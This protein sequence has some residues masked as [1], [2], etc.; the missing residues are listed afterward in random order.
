M[1]PKHAH[2][3]K[4]KNSYLGKN[5]YVFGF[6]KEMHADQVARQMKW[7]SPVIKVSPN[8]YV[9]N[10]PPPMR[11]RKRY[12]ID[13]S[14]ITT[15]TFD[16]SVSD[17]FT[18]INNVELKL[19]DE[20]LVDKSSNVMILKSEYTLDEMVPIDEADKIDQLERLYHIKKPG[21]INYAETMSDIILERYMFS[22]DEDDFLE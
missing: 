5:N 10:R 19:I 21:D 16:I 11:Q 6:I 17:F 7:M 1:F 2:M 4:Y 3:I 22:M 18:S 13:Q 8:T 12:A 9:I 20:V 14:L 15:K